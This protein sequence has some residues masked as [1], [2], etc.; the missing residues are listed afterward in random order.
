MRNSKVK[1]FSFQDYQYNRYHIIDTYVPDKWKLLPVDTIIPSILL[2]L[3][4]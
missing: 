2:A 4:N 3:S 1:K